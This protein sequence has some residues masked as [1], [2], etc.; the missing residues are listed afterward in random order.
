MSKLQLS[1][2]NGLKSS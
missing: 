2:Y 1:A